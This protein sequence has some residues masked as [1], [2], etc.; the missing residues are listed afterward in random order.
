VLGVLGECKALAHL[1]LRDD[2]LGD[3]G[4]WN[5]GG[6]AGGVQRAGSS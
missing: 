3:E 2:W 5:A 4:A 1:G 6:D